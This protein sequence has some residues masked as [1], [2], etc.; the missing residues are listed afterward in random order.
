MAA[1]GGVRLVPMT[2]ERF[3]TWQ[4]YSVAAYADE[5]VKSGRWSEDEALSRSEADFQGLLPRGLE[6]P[7]HRLWSV[8]D[9]ADEEVGILWIATDRR[10][11]HA[12]IYDIEMNPDRR[13]EGL[14][15][16]TLLAFEEWCRENGI[17][18]IGLHV[19]GHNEGAWRLY[20]RMGYVETNVNM[21]KRL[22]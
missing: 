11:S 17:T 7:G 3:V 1:A 14:G 10:P 4:A 2:P 6:T 16:A 22:S 18:S 5:N 8:V 13:G 12:F 21:E 15:T 19:F 9:S 20:K